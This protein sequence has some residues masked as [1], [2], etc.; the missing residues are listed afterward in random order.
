MNMMRRPNKRVGRGAE[1]EVISNHYDII[2]RV[3]VDEAQRLWRAAAA[4]ALTFAD[5]NDLDVEDML[6]PMEDPSVS[7]CL[8]MLL[9][10][11]D[12]PGC[13]FESFVLVPVDTAAGQVNRAEARQARDD[14]ASPLG[15]IKS[16]VG[17][18]K[19]V[20]YGRK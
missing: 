11:R 20:S 5:C 13:L 18:E 4:Y 2:M 1:T 10:P 7:A 19:L 12:L 3:S 6:G 15:R 16:A 17:R 14:R 9:G 8:S